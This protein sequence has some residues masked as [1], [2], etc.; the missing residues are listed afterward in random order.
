[1]RQ[2][3]ATPHLPTAWFLEAVLSRGFTSHKHQNCQWLSLPW[4]TLVEIKDN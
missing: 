3:L 4:K 2:V 1:M